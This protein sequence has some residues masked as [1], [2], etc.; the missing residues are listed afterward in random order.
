LLALS[1]SPGSPDGQLKDKSLGNIVRIILDQR[2]FDKKGKVIVGEFEFVTFPDVIEETCGDGMRDIRDEGAILLVE[3][4]PLLAREEKIGK[5]CADLVGDV[6]RLN[7][8]SPPVP[9]VTM[10]SGSAFSNEESPRAS[11]QA[12]PG[13][14]SSGVV[15]RRF[16]ARSS[17]SGIWRSM[18]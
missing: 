8:R 3:N 2:F 14:W 9:R 16:S 17:A 12:K 15:A 7:C 11:R 4:V 18:G 1:T 13:F 10:I 5:R 6:A